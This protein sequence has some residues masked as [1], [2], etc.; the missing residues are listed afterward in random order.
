MSFWFL[1]RTKTNDC[2]IYIYNWKHKSLF[3]MLHSLIVAAIWYIR[4]YHWSSF[5]NT[6]RVDVK[7]EEIV[8]RISTFCPFG[9]AK[10]YGGDPCVSFC[11]FGIAMA[12][13]T[14]TTGSMSQIRPRDA[15]HRAD[16][17]IR[18]RHCILFT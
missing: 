10:F 13:A 12:M 6:N 7:G 3:E 9:N 18:L 11:R 4:T 5:S 15:F 16:K 1:T 2:H 8:A 14:T 17:G